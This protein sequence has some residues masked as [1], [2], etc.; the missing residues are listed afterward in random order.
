MENDIL[1]QIAPV[2]Q[3]RIRNGIFERDMYRWEDLNF[4]TEYENI[5]IKDLDLWMEKYKNTGTTF[6]TL[7][8]KD[9]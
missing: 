3:S 2:E 4:T 8:Y 9:R 6:R 1:N 7:A 5:S